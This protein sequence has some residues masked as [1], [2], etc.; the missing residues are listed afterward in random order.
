MSGSI[1]KVNAMFEVSSINIRREKAGEDE[2]PIAIDVTL[3]AELGN[4]AVKGLFHSDHGYKDVL[5][6]LW[7]DRGE[8]ACVDV[9]Q[10][11]LTREMTGASVS[12]KTEL[13]HGVEFEH[14][15]VNK[16][17]IT[18]RPAG[19]VDVKL[20]VQANPTAEQIAKL[21]EFHGHEIRLVVMQRQGELLQDAA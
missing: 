16:V 12:M 5:G 9:D 21:T 18:P 8:L 2:G 13:G 15:N 19:L 20:R 4:K 3:K 11:R 7:T 10:I 6:Q 14:A 1:E 17:Q